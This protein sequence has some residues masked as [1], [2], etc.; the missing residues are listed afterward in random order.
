[1]YQFA[2]WKQNKYKHWLEN[3]WDELI[4]QLNHTIHV[5]GTLNYDSNLFCSV[6]LFYNN[7]CALL[8]IWQPVMNF[9]LLHWEC[10]LRVSEYLSNFCVISIVGSY[11]AVFT[12]N[13]FLKI[14]KYSWAAT[15]LRYLIT[16]S[17]SY[18]LCYISSK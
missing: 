14:K 6:S 5:Q 17:S 9:P 18:I 16:S 1:M 4:C 7:N 10:P 8:I 13:H 2:Y 3:S 12:W 15:Q 11:L